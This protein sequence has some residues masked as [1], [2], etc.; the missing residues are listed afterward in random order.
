MGIQLS[1]CEVAFSLLVW[2]RDFASESDYVLSRFQGVSIGLGLG[3]FLVLE[4]P[5][6]GNPTF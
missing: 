6:G 4:V 2:L 1:F 3:C 5:V